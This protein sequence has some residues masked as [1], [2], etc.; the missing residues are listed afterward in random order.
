MSYAPGNNTLNIRAVDFDRQ[1]HPILSN[2]ME[3]YEI[4]LENHMKVNNNYKKSVIFC[5]NAF[6]DGTGAVLNEEF[7]GRNFVT[8]HLA[9]L[10]SLQ[11]DDCFTN[12]LYKSRAE[13]ADMGLPINQPTWWRLQLE[14]LH[15]RQKYRKEDNTSISIETLFDRCKKGSRKF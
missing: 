12:D 6:T 7:F 2:I 10:R 1:L 13:F 5:N 11:F 3:S 15:C 4:L 8:A 9:R 14:L